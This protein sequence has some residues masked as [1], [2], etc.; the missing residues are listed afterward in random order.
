[1]KKLLAAASLAIGLAMVVPT[2]PAMATPVVDFGGGNVVFDGGNAATST[3][4]IFNPGLVT[5][6]TIAP[7]FGAPVTI[8]GT[9]SII[10]GAIGGCGVAACFDVAGTGTFNINGAAPDSLTG[11]LDLV[12]MYQVGIGG[13]TNVNAFANLTVSSATGLL[14][15]Y[16]VPGGIVSTTLQFAGNPNLT[17]LSGVSNTLDKTSSYSGTMTPVPEPS[18]L[19]LL[20]AG[21][22]GLAAYGRKKLMKG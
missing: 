14:A 12:N 10:P 13:G 3:T 8:T 4:F 7:L 22:L 9:F 15:G 19:L 21:L 17:A 18:S 16:L 20:G 11:T 2:S 6:P 5:L 1:M